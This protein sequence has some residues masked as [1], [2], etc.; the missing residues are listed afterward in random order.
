MVLTVLLAKIIENGVR[1]HHEPVILRANF[2]IFYKT[3][4]TLVLMNLH[5]PSSVTAHII[6]FLIWNIN[7][8]RY[9]TS[10]MIMTLFGWKRK[11]RIAIAI[12][13]FVMLVGLDSKPNHE[14]LFSSLLC[15]TIQRMS[16]IPS[17]QQLTNLLL[18]PQL[19]PKT[20]IRMILIVSET[21]N[22]ELLGKWTQY[23]K[24]YRT[25]EV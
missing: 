18:T 21:I 3:K 4:I 14:N 11:N 17:K 7:H 20:R 9:G 8:G 19:I 25:I 24:F 6:S 5:L 15:E 12:I 23:R 10:P 2:H 16:Q 13:T 1:K 22:N